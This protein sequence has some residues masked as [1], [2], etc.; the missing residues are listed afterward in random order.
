MATHLNRGKRPVIPKLTRVD[1]KVSH[2]RQRPLC[3]SV[4]TQRLLRVFPSPLRPDQ[5]VLRSPEGHRGYCRSR[6]HAE[7]RAGVLR[8]GLG[9][10]LR[11]RVGVSGLGF[12]FRGCG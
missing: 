3:P 6:L 5:P 9:L 2:G 8:R 1:G 12:G 10:G 11:V 7:Q 4:Y